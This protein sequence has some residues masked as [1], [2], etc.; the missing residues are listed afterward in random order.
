[1]NPIQQRIA[2]AEACGWVPEYAHIPTWNAAIN[3]L[4]GGYLPVL[5]LLFRRKEKCFKIENLPDYLNDLNA[6]HEAEKMMTEDQWLSYTINVL[7]AAKDGTFVIDRNMKTIAHA[8]A[9]QRAEAFLRT[10]G[11]WEDAK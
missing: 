3:D 2:I 8:T 5:T 7:M 1:M 11:K 4:K 9:A 10:I 6:M